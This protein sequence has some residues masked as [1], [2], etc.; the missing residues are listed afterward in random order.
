MVSTGPGTHPHRRLPRVGRRHR[1]VA[2]WGPMAV[3]GR[4][5][6]AATAT[7]GGRPCGS[8]TTYG[9]PVDRAELERAG[10]ALPGYLVGAIPDAPV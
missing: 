1:V 6:G 4:R 9:R 8:L 5:I 2:R 3:E 10:P 7:E